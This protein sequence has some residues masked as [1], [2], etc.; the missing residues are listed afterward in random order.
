[1]R[2]HRLGHRVGV[3]QAVPIGMDHDHDRQV[4]LTRKFEIALVMRGNCHNRA[5]AVTHQ[6]VVGDP[7]RDMLTRSGV[8]GIAAGEDAGFLARDRFA[9]DVGLAFGLLLIGAYLI[10]LGGRGH[11]FHQRMLGRKHH[12]GDAPERVGTG[13]EDLNPIAGFSSERDGRALRL[14]DPFLLQ[15][16]DKFGPVEPIIVEQLLGIGGSLKEPLLQVLADHGRAAAFAVAVIAV[17]LFSR[18]GGVAIRA[19]VNGREFLVCQPML[20]ELLKEPLCPA[21]ILGVRRNDFS[22]PVK[23]ITHGA[24][25]PA[26]AFNVGIGPFFGMDIVLD[27]SVF[28]RQTEGIETHREEYVVTLHALKAGTGVWGR[29]GVPMTDVKVAGRIGQH[30][31]GVELGFV[32]VALR[33][34]E[35]VRLPACLP[36]WLDLFG[37]ISWYCGWVDH[38]CSC[39]LLLRLPVCLLQK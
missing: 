20:V 4:E 26:H 39:S 29:H 24:Q 7:N 2:F 38:S 19:K 10:H 12:E 35:A 30:G 8:D 14:P 22:P 25:L 28:S 32:R 1:M 36:L 5:G 31:E 21:V 33:L 37:S 15:G 18:E 34:V 9:L 11:F 13:G 16:L 3:N 27:G 6:H 17:H 23:R